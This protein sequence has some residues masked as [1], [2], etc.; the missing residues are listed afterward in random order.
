MLS[1]NNETKQLI[2]GFA[3]ENPGV[4]ER[5]LFDKYEVLL[6]TTV[7]IQKV[8]NDEQ[9]IDKALFYVYTE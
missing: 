2:A 5:L 9:S 3:Q 6:Q 4:V 8:F 1:C 7:R